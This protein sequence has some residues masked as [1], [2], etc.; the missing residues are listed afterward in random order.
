V[1]LC[2]DERTGREAQVCAPGIQQL[3]AASRPL[4]EKKREVR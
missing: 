2:S 3:K 1:V 4:V